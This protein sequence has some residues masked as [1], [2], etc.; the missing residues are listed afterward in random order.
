[1]LT[2]REGYLGSQV[3][4]HSVPQLVRNWKQWHR[5]LSKLVACAMSFGAVVVCGAGS[6]AVTYLCEQDPCIST[7][8]WA[9]THGCHFE[10][11]RDGEFQLNDNSSS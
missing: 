6:H 3:K 7:S 9:R 10:D 5:Y 11:V 4:L 1:M 8:S 2:K